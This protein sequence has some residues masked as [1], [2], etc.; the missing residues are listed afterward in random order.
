MNDWVKNASTKVEQAAFKSVGEQTQTSWN[1][2]QRT[3]GDEITVK[4]DENTLESIAQ[5]KNLANQRADL[6][7]TMTDFTTYNT[8]DRFEKSL[9]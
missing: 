7:K 4:I 3:S 2:I 5:I 1:T 6:A 8:I 9:D